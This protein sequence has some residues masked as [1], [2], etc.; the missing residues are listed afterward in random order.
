MHRN[1]MPASKSNET[2]TADPANRMA[3]YRF[4]SLDIA[5]DE[6]WKTLAFRRKSAMLV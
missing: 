4:C 2:S 5:A 6:L 1:K 3:R